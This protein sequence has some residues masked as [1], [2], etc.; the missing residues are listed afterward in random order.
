MDKQKEQ[1][2]YNAAYSACLDRTNARFDQLIKDVPLS[3]EKD[4][5]DFGCGHGLL[6][7]HVAYKVRSYIGIDTSAELIKIARNRL[8][9]YPG[10]KA[11]FV[12]SSIEEFAN[13]NRGAADIGVAFD[14]SEHIED[15][16]WLRILVSIREV[17]RNGG[18]LY[19][20][21][22]NGNY[23]LEIMKKRSFILKQLPGHIAIRSPEDNARILKQAGFIN[24]NIKFIAHYNVLRYL[25]W[26]AYLP[27][28]G[29]FFKARLLIRA[30]K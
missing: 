6:L 21:T 7:P 23:V 17:L 25:H 28:V 10:M 14:V 30:D 11:G 1:N 15:G 9:E 13:K 29:R 18:Q 4:L 20:H 26:L 22:P 24:I 8:P 16:E 19:L 27:L 2:L 3:A 12:C 5:A